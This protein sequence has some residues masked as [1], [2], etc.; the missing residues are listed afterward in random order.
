MITCIRFKLAYFKLELFSRKSM[1]PKGKYHIH[2]ANNYSGVQHK[3]R[4]DLKYVWNPQ[5][6]TYSGRLLTIAVWYPEFK[7]DDLDLTN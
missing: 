3:D 2:N 6:F 5:F 4:D 1:Q 7:Y